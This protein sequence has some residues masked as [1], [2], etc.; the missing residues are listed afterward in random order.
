MKLD[1][2]T[3]LTPDPISLSIGTLR[4]P[5]L[6]EI[7]KLTFFKYGMYQVYIKL[8]PR[9]YYTVLNKNKN[10]GYWDTLSEEQKNEIS[11]YDLILSEEQLLHTYLEILNYFFVERIAFRDGLFFVMG[12]DESG[13]SNNESSGNEN[14]LDNVVGII[15]PITFNEVIDAI[16]QICCIKSE[17]PLDEATP[18]F[19]NE[20]AKKL[21]ERMLKA[22]EEQNKRRARE[23]H[24][25]T[26]LPNIIS[27]TAAKSNS[28]NIINIWDITVFQLYDQ[29]YKLRN[30]DIHY[31]NVV[32]TSVW[33]DEKNQFDQAFWYRNNF[34]KQP[35]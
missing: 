6:R 33:G 34:E 1:Y 9:D 35:N 8:T 27:A 24:V 18:K 21:Y 20:K 30:N 3:L 22:K 7:S 14:N 23:N 2:F 4:K 31:L 12:E 29:F 26:T 16:Q 5:T 17:D 19:K 11:I 13:S 15:N 25:N 10:N 28:L 32:R